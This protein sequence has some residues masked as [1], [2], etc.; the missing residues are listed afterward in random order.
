MVVFCCA[1]LM[2]SLRKDHPAAVRRHPSVEGN[3]GNCNKDHP[4][5][6]RRHPSTGGELR[7]DRDAELAIEIKNYLK[8]SGKI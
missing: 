4:A 7:Q 3:Y 6:V 8:R 1:L 5:A 2:F